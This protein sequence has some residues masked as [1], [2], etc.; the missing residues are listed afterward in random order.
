MITKQIN[1]Y[2]YDELNEK[3]KEK[4]L[5]DFRE[6]R[7]YPFLNDEMTCKAKELLKEYNIDIVKDFKVFYSLSYCQGDGAMF[8]GWFKFNDVDIFIKQRGLYYHS[9]SKELQFYNIEG[10]EIDDE[11]NFNTIYKEICKELEKYGY[12]CIESEQEK[13]YIENIFIE[14][15]YYFL[16]NGKFEQR[17]NLK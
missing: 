11:N 13:A 15:E 1:L 7:D 16:S 8:Q 2:T 12:S 17:G 6:N 14:E 9:N 4:A 10:K 5:N 3:A